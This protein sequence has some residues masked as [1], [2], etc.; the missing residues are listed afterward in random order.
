MTAGTPMARCPQSTYDAALAAL[1]DIRDRLET[2]LVAP[3]DVERVVAEAAAAADAA[4]A[5]LRRADL[6]VDMLSAHR[7]PPGAAF[8]R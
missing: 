2:G 8:R 6:A 4:R 1:H 3:E 7:S 5:A